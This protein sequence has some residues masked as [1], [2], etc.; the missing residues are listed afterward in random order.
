MISKYK[1]MRGMLKRKFA[2]DIAFSFCKKINSKQYREF[3]SQKTTTFAL[4]FLLQ[5]K[6][7]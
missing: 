2:R 6:A 1:I 4:A 7:L 5:I 3:I